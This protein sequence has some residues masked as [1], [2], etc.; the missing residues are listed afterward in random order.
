MGLS[1]KRKKV[2]SRKA[3]SEKSWETPSRVSTTVTKMGIS[4]FVLG[5]FLWVTGRSG[6]ACTPM[7]VDI[8]YLQVIDTFL[9]DERIARDEGGQP[10][11]RDT[12]VMQELYAWRYILLP[13]EPEH[14]LRDAGPAVPA[15]EVHPE[16]HQ[17]A[18]PRRRRHVRC[19]AVTLHWETPGQA[20][21]TGRPAIARLSWTTG[22][23]GA[24]GQSSLSGQ[25]TVNRWSIITLSHARVTWQTESGVKK[26]CWL[27]AFIG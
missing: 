19:Q 10:V 11:G 16:G 3:L 20:R 17:P 21:G 27:E 22:R 8:T 24:G 5:H 9:E 12:S 13:V 2:F 15:G 18:Q 7:S 26:I 25:L 23:A 1:R 4:L 14:H 6:Q